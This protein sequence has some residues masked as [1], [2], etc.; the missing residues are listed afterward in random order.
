MTSKCRELT[1]GSEFV[2]EHSGT[3]I[4]HCTNLPPTIP[5]A[6]KPVGGNFIPP[7]EEGKQVV[8]MLTNGP[9]MVFN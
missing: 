8:E 4:N 1:L 7:C 3:S 2:L 6:C 5:G 9:G